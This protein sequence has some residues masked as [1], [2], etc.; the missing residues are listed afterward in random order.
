M[1]VVAYVDD[2]LIATKG[3]LDKHH[4]QVSKV[5][6]LLLDNTMCLEIDKCVFDQHGTTHL[7][8]IVSGKELRMD[9][10]KAKAILDWPSPTSR[11]QVPQLLGSWNF[12]GRF[13]HNFSG[14]VSPITDLLKQDRDFKWGEL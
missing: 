14:I 2:L 6:Q 8:S 11:K 4:R 13:L 7:G 9:P 10:D 5:F 1:V 3:S 12:Y